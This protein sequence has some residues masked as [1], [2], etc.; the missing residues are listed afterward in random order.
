MGL[1]TCWL[2]YP[3]TSSTYYTTET[4]TNNCARLKLDRIRSIGLEVRIVER[5]LDKRIDIQVQGLG[6]SM[7][8]A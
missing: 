7:Q 6:E 4:K 8:E 3:P 1:N 2:F 5:H